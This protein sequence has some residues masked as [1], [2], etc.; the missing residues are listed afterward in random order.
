MS[1]SFDRAAGYYDAT[2]G[3]PPDVVG[4]VATAIFDAAGAGPG[5]QWFEPGVGTGRI[6]LPLIERGCHY[7]G[8]DL[9]PRMLDVLRAKLAA[10]IPDWPSRVTLVEGDITALPF[11]DAAFDVAVA[12]HIFHLVSPWETALDEVVRVL[13]RPAVFLLC[14]NEHVPPDDVDVDAVWGRIRAEELA[15]YEG[16]TPAPVAVMS[17]RPGRE[18]VI[19]ALRHRGFVVDAV[20]PV[21]WQEMRTPLDDVERITTRVLSNT[22]TMP[23]DA[24]AAAASR[25]RDWAMTTYGAR[26]SELRPVTHRFTITRTRLSAANT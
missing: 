6:A 5:S 7:T 9:S 14:G 1:I 21:E 16:H 11:P 19:D 26:L 4:R 20:P 12:V 24:F 22:W 10:S 8:V 2:R 25:L 3:F 18:D 23:D 17:R 13:R 15:R